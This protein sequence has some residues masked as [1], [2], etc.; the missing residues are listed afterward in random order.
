MLGH[1]IANHYE[2]DNNEMTHSAFLTILH[3]TIGKLSPI[4]VMCIDNNNKYETK[5]KAYKINLSLPH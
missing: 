4:T 3:C 5:F 2:S 1:N